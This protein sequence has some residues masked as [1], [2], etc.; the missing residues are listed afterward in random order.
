[1][2]NRSLIDGTFRG[3]YGL[4][5]DTTGFG[6]LSRLRVVT[7]FRRQF[8]SMNFRTEAWSA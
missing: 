8:R 3:M 6:K 4:R 2:S 1:M 7:G 5:A